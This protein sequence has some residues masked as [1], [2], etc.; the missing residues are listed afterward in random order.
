MKDILFFVLV[1]FMVHT[2]VQIE[3]RN[4]LAGTIMPRTGHEKWRG[5][6]YGYEEVWRR[7]KGIPAAAELTPNERLRM[8]ADILRAQRR[9][10][11]LIW[12]WTFGLLQC[13]LTPI[14]FIYCVIRLK[15]ETRKTYRSAYAVSFA[16][17]LLCSASLYY[18][19]Y[20]GSLSW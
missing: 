18:R 9:D 14:A 5:T 7:S 6:A 11:L 2:M 19:S 17:I 16:L 20:F 3:V 10:A 8:K 15:T 4:Y 1:A 13:L 12:V